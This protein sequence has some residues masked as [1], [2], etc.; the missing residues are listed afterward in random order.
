MLVSKCIVKPFA[1]SRYMMMNH[2]NEYSLS[3]FIRTRPRLIT[4]DM[5]KCICKDLAMA[6]QYIHEVIFFLFLRFANT[7]RR[8][9]KNSEWTF[10]VCFF[11]GVDIFAWFDK[12]F[13]FR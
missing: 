9:I 4:L 7:K 3:K 2:C 10:S 12:H 5:I 13:N 8:S 1:I 6:L 11:K